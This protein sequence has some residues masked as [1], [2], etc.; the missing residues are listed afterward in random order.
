[1]EPSSTAL[2]LAPYMETLLGVAGALLLALLSLLT[3]ALY[4]WANRRA[5]LTQTEIDEK[6][7]DLLN[8]IGH[9]GIDYGVEFARNRFGGT[10]PLT[11][12]MK[13]DIVKMAAEYLLRAGTDTL[14]RFGLDN[15]QQIEDF[16]LARLPENATFGTVP[17]AVT[18]TPISQP[19]QQ[20]IVVEAPREPA[21]A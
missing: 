12:E 15:K 4:S 19:T 16:I 1:M 3:K 7:R 20:N 18:T 2:N 11:I 21:K 14:K 10:T 9:R 13:N 8:S 17:G 6:L 5:D